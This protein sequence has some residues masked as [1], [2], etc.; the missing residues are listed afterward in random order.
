M[1][2]E[3][4]VQRQRVNISLLPQE[5]HKVLLTKQS[6]WLLADTLYKFQID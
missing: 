2:D 3:H 4:A 5:V 6:S 1:P